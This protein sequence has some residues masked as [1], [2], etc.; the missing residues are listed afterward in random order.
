MDVQ[1]GVDDATQAA[2]RAVLE[3]VRAALCQSGKR[4]LRD[5]A[6]CVQDFRAETLRCPEFCAF[7]RELADR[8]DG[9]SLDAILQDRR[10]RGRRIRD[11]ETVF[12][13]IELIESIRQRDRCNLR[14]A[15]ATAFREFAVLRETNKTPEGIRA[16]YYRHK[17]RYDIFKSVR[18][19]P[20]SELAEREWSR[21]NDRDP[22]GE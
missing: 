3:A 4:R 12:S 14:K 8:G 21:P 1:V 6:R 10:K 22:P 17:K 16:D 5:L 19:I 15:I 13:E 11:A 9:R 7:V 2:G 20:A 18:Y